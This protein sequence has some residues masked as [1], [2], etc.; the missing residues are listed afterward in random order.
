MLIPDSVLLPDALS[1]TEGMGDD[2]FYMYRLTGTVSSGLA[3]S[4]L[5]TALEDWI[6]IV[7]PILVI[8]YPT[9][10]FLKHIIHNSL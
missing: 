7:H 1:E 2:R 10:S 8:K 9:H 4:V 6:G 5:M 3:S